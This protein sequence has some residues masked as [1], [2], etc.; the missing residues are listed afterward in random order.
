MVTNL[1]AKYTDVINLLQR[2]IEAEWENYELALQGG[3]QF[4]ELKQIRD[5]I[6]DL[7]NAMEKLKEMN[8]NQE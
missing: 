5:K 4:W 3:K 8:H 2:E 7:E 6:H 1:F